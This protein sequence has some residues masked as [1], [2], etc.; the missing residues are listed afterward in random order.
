MGLDD[1]FALLLYG[2]D[3]LY[4]LHVLDTALSNKCENHV[5]KALAIINLTTIG[6]MFMIGRGDPK[7]LRE[8]LR[9]PLK[10]DP[11]LHESHSQS[12]H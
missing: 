9:N 12:I 10:M 8:A 1:A 3:K 7:I 2:Y 11:H 6:Y 4:L 5:Y